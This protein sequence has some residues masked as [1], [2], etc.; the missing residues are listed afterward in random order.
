MFDLKAAER[1]HATG[2]RSENRTKLL[3]GAPTEINCMLHPLNRK[4]TD[5]LQNSSEEER[6][7]CVAQGQGSPYTSLVFFGGKKDPDELRPVDYREINKWTKRDRNPL[8][9][10]QTAP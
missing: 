3:L 4:E 9:N 8:S 7:G 1:F 10:I 2:R 5:I 6:K